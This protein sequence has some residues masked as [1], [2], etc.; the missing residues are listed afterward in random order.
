MNH[1]F[2]LFFSL[3]CFVTSSFGQSSVN[4]GGHDI[5]NGSGSA[6][7]S[8]GQ[9]KS[10]FTENSGGSVSSGVQQTYQVESTG[11]QT[12]LAEEIKLKV[13]PNPSTDML[14][15]SLN[16]KTQMTMSVKLSSLEGKTIKEVTTS[17]LNTS[18]DLSSLPK[19]TYLLSLE[20]EG[21]KNPITYR[22]IKK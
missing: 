9:T 12:K 4:S 17:A 16:P 10:T 20:L 11:I 22:I 3:V 5:K 21:Y 2:I 6:S 19:T 15:I 13:Y 8:L 14:S 18:I 1:I 7:I